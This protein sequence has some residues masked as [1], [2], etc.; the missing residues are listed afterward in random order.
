MDRGKLYL[1]AKDAVSLSCLCSGCGST[2]AFVSTKSCQRSLMMP[3]S[4][5]ALIVSRRLAASVTSGRSFRIRPGK[6]R[7]H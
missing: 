6:T 3:Q 7:A 2:R 5:A 1:A 4:S